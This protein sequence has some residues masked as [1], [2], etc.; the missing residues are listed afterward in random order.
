VRNSLICL[1]LTVLATASSAQVPTDAPAFSSDEIAIYRDFL[2]HYPEQPSEMIGMQDT[3]IPFVV[4]MAFAEERDPPKLNLRS[5]KHK[6]RKLPPEIMTLTDE[7]AV[8]SRARAEGKPIYPDLEN[9]LKLSEIAFD[10]KHGNAAF[11]YSSMQGKGGTSGTVV[12]ERI[13]G[14]WK[15][16][17]PILNF[18]IA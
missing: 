8:A 15:Q 18:R 11:I 6:G 3:T 17:P 4:A 14:R 9:R 13:N 12:Y 2:L 7:N 5:P 1:Y 10:R 16:K